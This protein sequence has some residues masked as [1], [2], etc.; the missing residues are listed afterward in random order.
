[1]KKFSILLSLALAVGFTA[2]DDIEDP[3]PPQSNPQEAIMAADGI[4]VAHMLPTDLNL[5]DFVDSELGVPVLKITSVDNQP[6]G[7]EV[8]VEM[9][10]SATEDF[11][12][13][14]SVLTTVVDNVAY[15][16][17][18]D[19]DNA[20][21]QLFGKSPAAKTTYVRFELTL[22]H[23]GTTVRFGGADTYFDASSV[24]VTPIDLGIK[25][26]SAYYVITDAAFG[27]GWDASAIK[28]GH[29]DQNVY[30]DPVFT[31]ICTLPAG[32]IQF[33]GAESMVK[34]KAD[35][36]N[37]FKY[38]WGPA[39]SAMSGELIYG[40]NSRPVTIAKAGE[41]T[42]TIN[43]ME[44]TFTVKA[45]S[46]K[47]Y[48]V[49]AFNGWGHDVNVFI[50]ER[51]GGVHSG[52]VDMSKAGNKAFEFKFS[53]QLNWNEGSTAYGV[54]AE[55]NLL[56]TDPGAKNLKLDKG[57]IYYFKVDTE[58]MI[59]EAMEITSF[60]IVGDATPGGWDAET[61]LTYAGGLVWKGEVALVGGKEYKF[62]ANN[63]W[64]FSLGGSLDNLN[65]NNAPN[66][67]CAEDG[68]YEITLNLSNNQTWK[69]SVVK[70]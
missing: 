25:I 23:N 16:N 39:E 26:E 51:N 55:A 27:D 33:M 12:K 18:L 41:Y 10:V 8:N 4:A 38:A 28:L 59:W 64:D 66:F 3:M 37:E 61:P 69:A 68:T 58:K 24:N 50:Y 42:V 31:S 11:K 7:S 60:G 54:G 1:M 19:I 46:P 9:Q 57:G 2:C 52:L 43:M 40:E 44:G 36:G 47:L 63:K 35:A 5:K 32:S 53:T 70:K 29:S 34:A 13:P 49:G 14:V 30:D 6:A 20:H 22:T 21:R 17:Y 45:Y 62:R 67:K 65:E 56:S 48:A 15:A